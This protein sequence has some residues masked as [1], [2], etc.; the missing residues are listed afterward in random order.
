[1]LFWALKKTLGPEI[2]T[3][4]VHGAWIKIY[5][6]MLT[7]IVPV[8]VAYEINHKDDYKPIIVKRMTTLVPL[9]SNV[10]LSGDETS[11]SVCARQASQCPQAHHSKIQHQDTSITSRHEYVREVVHVPELQSSTQ[12]M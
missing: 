4:A 9:S 1:M 8:A 2:Y 12:Y 7:V 5:S 6:K 3:P 10:V 11:M